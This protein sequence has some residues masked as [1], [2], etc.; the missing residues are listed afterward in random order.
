MVEEPYPPDPM[1]PPDV[2][3]VHL[4]KYQRD[5]KLGAVEASV[6]EYAEGRG[7]Y[8][9]GWVYRVFFH[10]VDEP[11]I[12]GEHYL[13]YDRKTSVPKVLTDLEGRWEWEDGD[14]SWMK[15]LDENPGKKKRVPR[16][17]GPKQ[18]SDKVLIAEVRRLWDAYYERPTKARLL[19]VGEQIVIMKSKVSKGLKK[20]LAKLEPVFDKAWFDEGLGGIENKQRPRRRVH[21]DRLKGGLADI[22]ATAAAKKKNPAKPFDDVGLI[23]IPSD[24][25]ERALIFLINP[26]ILDIDDAVIGF[27]WLGDMNEEW[28]LKAKSYSPVLRVAQSVAKKGYGPILYEAALMFASEQGGWLMPGAKTSDRARPIWEKM[29][30]RKDVNSTEVDLAEPQDDDVLDRMYDINASARLVKDRDEALDRGAKWMKDAAEDQSYSRQEIEVLLWDRG[31]AFFANE[32]YRNPRPARTPRRKQIRTPKKNPKATPKKKAAK[33]RTAGRRKKAQTRKRNPG[34]GGV[35]EN[36]TMVREELAE[37]PDFPMGEGFQEWAQDWAEENRVAMAWLEEGI[38]QALT[39][40]LNRGLSPSVALATARRDNIWNP[41]NVYEYAY[42]ADPSRTNRPVRIQSTEDLHDGTWSVFA[43]YGDIESPDYDFD[44]IKRWTAPRVRTEAEGLATVIRAIDRWAALEQ[45]V[46]HNNPRP[47]QKP[48]TPR[49]RVKSKRRKNPGDEISAILSKRNAEWDQRTER[50][51]LKRVKRGIEELM[52]QRGHDKVGEGSSRMVYRKSPGSVLKIDV[53]IFDRDIDHPPGGQNETEWSCIESVGDNPLVPRLIDR[54]DDY[55]WIVLEEL[56]PV[57]EA[58]FK[59]KTGIDF[60][61]F[62]KAMFELFGLLDAPS[63]ERLRVRLGRAPTMSSQNTDK[64]ADAIAD[65]LRTCATE[66][67]ELLVIHHWGLNQ[68]GEL[69]LMDL[70]VHADE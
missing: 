9:P 65:V 63:I 32:T 16:T 53:G 26:N 69:K 55:G 31:S 70:G 1:D 17:R 14:W 4:G 12:G 44:S 39:T 24:S 67:I 43:V 28:D 8:A 40:H 29:L 5:T 38:D 37:Q 59:E 54:A 66:H 48:D 46:L 57:S 23:I 47:A 6:F 34:R 62:R 30:A 22:K 27:I 35:Y 58:E 25:R 50:G 60:Q 20:E 19:A 2:G 42:S 7:V 10:K 41:F 49:R 61:D 64:F 15:D 56:N 52:E 13:E 33:K 45:P 51:N 68:A 21:K 11:L 18:K 3:I 36:L